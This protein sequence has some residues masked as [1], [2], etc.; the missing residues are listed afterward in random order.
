MGKKPNPYN[1]INAGVTHHI[2]KIIDGDH[3]Q[4]ALGTIDKN[5]YPMV[6]KLFQCVTLTIYTSYSVT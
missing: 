5:G 3:Q 4:A 6:L 2:K 1:D